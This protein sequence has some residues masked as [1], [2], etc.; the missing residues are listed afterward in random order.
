M[1]SRVLEQEI[2]KI[3][4]VQRAE[5]TEYFLYGKLSRAIKNPHNKDILERIARDELAHHNYWSK[6]TGDGAKPSRFKIWLYYLIARIFGIT[7][8][9]KLMEMGEKLAQEVYEEIAQVIPE[10]RNI[11]EDEVEHEKTLIGLIDEER[12]EYTSDIVRG[13]NVALVELTGTLAGL[14]L[15]IPETRLI[16]TAGLIAG[17]VMVLSVA[18]TEYLATKTGEGVHSP[19]KAVF[20]GGLANVFTLLFLVFPYLIFSNIYFS[21]GFM[22]FNAIIVIFLFSF[23]ISVAKDISLRKRFL[24]MTLVSLGVAALAFGIGLLARSLLHIEI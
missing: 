4:G 11:A 24:E 5:I 16:L 10:A 6:F 3:L 18:S 8:G 17:S 7:F 13:L 15:A 1:E 19:L 12:L 23:Y 22:I 14:T 9:L 21:L 2:K 20:Y